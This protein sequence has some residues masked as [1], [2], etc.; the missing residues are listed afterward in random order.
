MV[1][2]HETSPISMTH[3]VQPISVRDG[4]K[5]MESGSESGT[6]ASPMSRTT[7]RREVNRPSTPEVYADA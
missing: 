1:S 2:P 7:H 3:H 4:E 5:K 6:S